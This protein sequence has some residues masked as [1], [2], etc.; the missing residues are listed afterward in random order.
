MTE[1]EST[2]PG[3]P[4]RNYNYHDHTNDSQATTGRVDQVIV[5]AEPPEFGP[6][7]ARALIRLLV[8]VH[9]RR[10]STADISMEES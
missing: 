5:P 4:N 9:H 10:Q 2:S 3:I 7:A 8:A 6:A 1:C